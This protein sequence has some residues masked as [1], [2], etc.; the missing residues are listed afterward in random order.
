LTSK[1]ALAR[2]ASWVRQRREELELTQDAL[3]ERTGYRKAHI[4][5]VETRRIADPPLSLLQTLSKH[6]E[7]PISVPLTE[8]GYLKPQSS[9]E[10]HVMRVIHYY[11]QLAPDDQELI[12]QLIRTMVKQRER[13]QEKS[14]NKPKR[15]MA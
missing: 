15:K 8:M 14:D 9:P 13:K 6:L 1:D 3:A 7:V 5:K 2:L 10:P 4:S 12:E 11:Q